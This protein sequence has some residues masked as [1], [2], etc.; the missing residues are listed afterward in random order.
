MGLGDYDVLAFWPG[1]DLL[2]NIED[3]DILPPFC[4]KDAKTIR[5]EIFGRCNR[6]EGYL[7][8]V[9]RRAL[10][11]SQHV[12]RISD[13]FGWKVNSKELPAVISIFVSRH[14]YWWTKFP[15]R[16]TNV[17]FVRIDL[18]DDFLRDL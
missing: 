15:P 14:S 7:R 1:K 4:L 10:H 16:S 13:I 2:L 17:H 9:E 8:K 12:Q 6:N 5:E 3:K 18:L 11:L